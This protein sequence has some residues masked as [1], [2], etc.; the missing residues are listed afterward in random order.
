MLTGAKDVPGVIPA[1]NEGQESDREM[2]SVS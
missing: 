2:S 1:L